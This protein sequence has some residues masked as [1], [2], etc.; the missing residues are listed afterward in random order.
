MKIGVTSVTFRQMDVDQ[1]IELARQ[2]GLDGIEWGG[3]VHV[4]P[5]DTALAVS[6]R[7]KCEKAGLMIFSYGSYYRGGEITEF[8]PVLETAKI[9]G[10]PVIRVWA[11]EQCPH[12]ISDEQFAALTEHLKQAADLAA[13]WGIS[14]G[15]EYHRG[16]MTQTKEGAFRL[17][18]AVDRPNLYTYWQ[19]NPDLPT[20]EHIEEL[21]V[22]K[23]WICACH[24]FCWSAGNERHELE[25]GKA[26]WTQYL[27]E[28]SQTGCKNLILEF[29]KED[30]PKIFQKDV[31]TL[32][33][34]H[35]SSNLLKAAFLCDGDRIFQVYDC[36][37]LRDLDEKFDLPRRVISSHQLE[38]E[39]EQLS[40]VEYLFSTWGMPSL[41]E[42]QIQQYFP[43]LKGVFYAAGSVQA[44]A[45]PFLNSGVRV[46]SAWGANAIPVAE[47]TV[48]QII[49]ASKGFFQGVRR[50]RQKNRMASHQFSSSQP[51]NYQI[52]I[53]ILGAGMIGQMVI[54]RLMDYDLEVLVYDPFVSDSVLEQYHAKRADLDVIFRECQVISNHIANLPATVGMLQY[55][56]FSA[57]KHNATFI[58]TGRGAQV[59]EEDLIRA[60]EEEPDRTAVLD[61]TFP[62]PP[63]PE[64][65]LN[66]ME[67]VFLTPHIAGSMGQEVARMGR[68]MAQEAVLAIDGAVCPYEVT[69]KMLETMA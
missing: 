61:V 36:Q 44:F 11:G 40:K 33:Q 20:E 52:K 69:E 66:T 23:P 39:K 46:F 34:W 62:E 63:L 64:S 38:E 8:I 32:K 27:K 31:Q 41:N 53:G 68:Y 45:R 49:L 21:Q 3:D 17:L 56:H 2:S 57:M 16:T 67:N 48:A 47:Y 14:L 12:E 43:K 19:P 22:L 42:E 1:I 35:E 65:P 7:K 28:L 18:K 6:V 10:A 54:K 15:L 59:V 50:Y 24:V 25:Q 29:V 60:L 5:G 9:L 58:N 30:D 37:T 51:G 55:K 13:Q 4:I 26:E